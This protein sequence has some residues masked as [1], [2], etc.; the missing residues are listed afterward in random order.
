MG[1]RPRVAGRMTKDYANR[2]VLQ[3]S[4]QT[5]QRI[6]LNQGRTRIPRTDHIICR[7]S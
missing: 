1:I 7:L 5:P 3:I 2:N 6:G 4:R